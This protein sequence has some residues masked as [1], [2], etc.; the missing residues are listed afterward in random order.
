MHSLFTWQ[1]VNNKMRDP[2]VVE[3]EKLLALMHVQ[4]C[5]ELYREQL[6]NGRYFIV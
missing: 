4:F 6:R 3:M 1:R 2:H 5:F